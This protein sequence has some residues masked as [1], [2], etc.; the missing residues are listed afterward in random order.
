V[1]ALPV[2]LRIAARELRGGLKG[3]RI[4][5]ACLALGVAII[6]G[7]GSLAEGVRTALREDAR[8]LLGG[9]VEVSFTHREMT[10]DQRAALRA[11]GAV[12]RFAEM[13]AMGRTDD[14]RTLI[15]LKAID[16]A[17]PLLGDLMLETGPA[18]RQDL[19]NIL[20]ER[21]GARGVAL[22]RATMT[23]LGVNIGDTVRIGDAALVVRAVI[24][25]EPDRTTNPI[26][27]GPRAMIAYD[28][29][30]S[31]G[32]VQP[33]SLV[34]YAYRV[35]LDR[36][37]E[38]R[39]FVRGLTAQFPDAGWRIRGLTDAAPG[40]QRWID[41][42]AMFLTLV[43]LTALL[44]GGVGVAN[45]VRNYLDGKRHTIATLK[46][47][48]VTGRA[49][50]AVYLTQIMALALLGVFVGIILG[51]A[52]PALFG[53][54]VARQVG[55]TARFGLYPAPLLLAS[56]FG[57]LIALAFSLWPLGRAREIAPAAL[58]R[59][60][61]APTRSWPR[62]AIVLGTAAS[63]AAL[64][65]LTV[66][67]TPDR[68]LALWFVLGA[69][70]TFVLF[71]LAA[72]AVAAVARHLR[73]IR[74]PAMRLA[75]ANM[76]RPGSTTPSI[77]LS[78][79]LGLTVLVLI[80]Q[81]QGNLLRELRT[82][83]PAIAPSF[84]FIDIQPDQLA[85]FETAVRATPGLIDLRHVP[86]LRGRI[87]RL[88][89][90]PIDQVRVSP[91]A[92]W[93]IGS[94]RGLTYAAHPPQDT[95]IVAGEWWPPDYNG[96]PLVSFDVNL[97]RGMGLNLGD[98]ITINVLGIEVDARIANLR[99]I[100]WTSLGIN[101]T[102]VFAPGTLE[103][104]PQTFIA[105]AAVPRGQE[106]DL[107]RRITEAMPNV[108]SIRIRNALATIEGVLSS[109]ADAARVTA[110]VT[111]IAGIL[112][113]AGAMV[114][115]QRRRIYDAVVL[116]VL[117]ARRRDVMVAFLIEF[118]LIGLAAGVVAAVIGTICAAG[119]MAA[120]FRFAF[121]PDMPMVATIVLTAVWVA[122]VLGLA[123]TWRA[124]GQKP[125]PVLR[126]A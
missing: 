62:P 126:H 49:V 125:A 21:D 103:G 87:T 91:E 33:G 23:R 104:A 100:D 28:A 9:D 85:Q 116:K 29:L 25:Q 26:T 89:G 65:A 48:G 67:T 71:W 119:V 68:F 88:N 54:L 82:Q 45:A 93:A 2:P 61:V 109:I 8:L 72:R 58:F 108:S 105:T 17:Y 73:R 1:S 80:T 75:L 63:L 113:L 57:L 16:E 102:L 60:I 10:E 115:T 94:D 50:T 47:L 118:G 97:A 27:L 77:I 96:P 6:A 70:G 35:R 15:E 59:D 84:F 64:A 86:S 124:L 78:L 42:I 121:V 53:P 19:A 79:G 92:Q 36:P 41:R 52:L 90:T 20:G 30:A 4:F 44:V 111:L 11:G 55:V 117:G 95:R 34:R 38:A 5:L 37:E 39:D 76:H 24:V 32:L 120:Y 7:V 18:S 106:D 40:L 123:G 110:A 43:G 122:G 12:S 107:E 22:E 99:V 81:I 74:Q 66:M 14:R 112:V 114:A 46:C 98:T 51:V 69:A 13:R 101:F 3:F 31:T 56:L 83:L